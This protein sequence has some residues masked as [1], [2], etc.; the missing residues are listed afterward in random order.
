MCIPVYAIMGAEEL[1]V[2]VVVKLESK[3]KYSENALLSA[4]RKY[5]KRRAFFAA[6]YLALQTGPT[7][8]FHFADIEPW[9][10]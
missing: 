8:A 9:V 2:V 1:F 3:V 7:S 10:L 5:A 6:L 4:E